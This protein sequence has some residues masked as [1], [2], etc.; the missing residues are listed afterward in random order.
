VIPTKL[1][2]RYAVVFGGKRDYYQVPLALEAVGALDS[3]HT[4]LYSPDWATE[5][6]SPGRLPRRL[7][8]Y[9]EKLTGRHH[10]GIPTRV[11]TSHARRRALGIAWR[12]LLGRDTASLNRRLCTELGHSA[13]RALRGRECGAIV[14]SYYW[15][16]FLDGVGEAG[17]NG[18]RVLF[19]VHPLP[20]QV[21]E[22]LASDRAR[23]SSV[24]APPREEELLSEE[25]VR[26]YEQA[27]TKADFVLTSSQFV[28]RGFE[29]L[30]YPRHR[31][32]VVPYGG[33]FTSRK[34]DVEPPRIRRRRVGP[35][36]LLFVG[37]VL[38]RKGL[39]H[40]LAALRLV[41]PGEVELTMVCREV[42]DLESLLPLPANVHLRRAVPDTELTQLFNEHDL[43]V[44]PSVV[45][46]FGL[47]YLEALNCGLPIICTENTGGPDILDAG[48]GGVVVPAGDP[49]TLAWE[50][51]RLAES[52]SLLG[53]LREEAAVVA[54]EFTWEK[55]RTRLIDALA[56]MEDAVG[57]GIEQKATAT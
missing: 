18:P 52:D 31:V 40:L 22:V 37:Q 33:D 56:K 12:N 29:K 45:E 30:G 17:V 50:I 20:S 7:D 42:R 25:A 10:P 16:G 23:P 5:L 57:R 41:D 28:A 48:G 47:V 34:V 44:M 49:S 11:V 8:V 27:A 55:Y 4:D 2:Y 24:P 38:Y 43:F 53:Q 1:A 14:Y 35:L 19:Q 54:S 3:L 32:Y 36:R 46:G 15:L 9:L 21:R 39:H 51:E 26:E 13:G 6:L